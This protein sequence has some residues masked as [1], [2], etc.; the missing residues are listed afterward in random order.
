MQHEAQV[1]LPR[2]KGRT[3]SNNKGDKRQQGEVRFDSTEL[4]ENTRLTT[5]DVYIVHTHTQKC[6]IKS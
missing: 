1:A 2:K 5:E 6:L 4:D 3:G